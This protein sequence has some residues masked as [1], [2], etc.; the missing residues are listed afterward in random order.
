MTLQMSLC[1]KMRTR[2]Q[3]SIA[4]HRCQGMLMMLNLLAS[5]SSTTSMTSQSTSS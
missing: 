4:T 5:I 1:A 3:I 2:T